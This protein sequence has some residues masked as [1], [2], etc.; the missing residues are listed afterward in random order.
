MGN[1]TFFGQQ[2]TK[3][4]VPPA[5]T[6]RGAGTFPLIAHRIYHHVR[7]IT[8]LNSHAVSNFSLAV[9]VFLKCSTLCGLNNRNLFPQNM[10]AEN[11]ELP[12]SRISL[13]RTLILACQFLLLT[14]S[15]HGFIC[16]N[17]HP[18]SLSYEPKSCV[19]RVS[20]SYVL[21][22]FIL[23]FLFS[24][25]PG[26]VLRH[27]IVTLGYEWESTDQHTTL[28]TSRNCDGITTSYYLFLLL[29]LNSQ[30]VSK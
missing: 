21:L 10:K 19:R 28:T 7:N 23:S 5:L 27:W 12:L 22:N 20:Y 15:S 11:S 8:M 16:T 18:V 4:I 13:L 26:H 3:E 24:C 14:A 30:L 9:L 1:V 2:S 29:Q 17:T 25:K 6:F